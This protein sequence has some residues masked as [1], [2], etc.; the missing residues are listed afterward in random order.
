MREKRKLA[1]IVFTDIVGYT[2][3]MS[4]D[5]P[6]ALRILEKNRELQQLIV[7]KHHGKF[8]KE[9][10]D[11]T[12]LSFR[13]TLDAVNCALEI[14]CAIK[15]DE[16]LKLRIGIHLGDIVFRGGDVFGDGVNVA[17]RVEQHAASGCICVSEPVYE[18]IKNKPGIDAEYVGE[19][20]LKNVENPVKLY[21]LRKE[22][23]AKPSKSL[24]WSKKWLWLRER[25]FASIAIVILGVFAVISIINLIK[26]RE[27]VKN[28]D[29]GLIAVA[30]FENKSGDESLDPIGFMASD[31]ITQGIAGTGLVSVVPSFTL[32][33]IEGIHQNMDGI[34][35]L[36]KETQ[37]QTIITGVFYKQGN[38]IQFHSNVVDAADGEILN[39]VGPVKGPTSDPLKSIEILRQKLMG[40][41]AANFDQYFISFSDRTLQPPLFDA[42][43]EFLAGQELYYQ[44]K[45]HEAIHHFY[46]AAK[47]DTS[48]FL[49][50]IWASGVHFSNGFT[51]DN[52]DEYHRSDSL[53]KIIKKH[54]GKLTPGEQHL[55]DY[56][57]AWE[58]GDLEGA[59][60]AARLTAQ[61][62]LVFKYE[63]GWAALRAN[64]LKASIDVMTALEPDKYLFKGRYWW[65]L[66][67]AHHLSG[68]YKKE[69]KI[70]QQGRN[71]HPELFSALW[72]ELRALSAIGNIDEITRLYEQS[73]N[74]PSEPYWN[75]GYLMLW[76][77][78]ELHVH[79]YKDESKQSINYAIDWYNAHPD[80]DYRYGLAQAYYIAE[81][82]SRSRAIFETLAKENP[83]NINYQGYLGVIAVRTGN[84]KQ[85]E[86]I[87]ML[88][89]DPS[90][91]YL[92]GLN[93]CW[94]ARISALS[95]DKEKA[96]H[97]IR[98]AIAQGFDYY[99]LH[100]IIDFESMYD[101]PP[102]MDL[103]KSKK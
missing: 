5:E 1:A 6:E 11:G 13:S 36:A 61:Y 92:F 74:F 15:D 97:L 9:M 75:P 81:Q 26:N 72:N 30:V 64:H 67:K 40:S 78:T 79:G 56:L 14:Q 88:L 2:R 38:E 96:I 28:L 94:Q 83:G 31:W 20:Y 68:N 82:W 84:I 60:Q 4:R 49:P 45:F 43:Q 52:I 101:Y 87:S 95:D 58:K 62:N 34:L 18:T 8:L 32:E 89:A 42:Y 41:L 46:I 63:L 12:L 53:N 77:A 39:A 102:F 86:T 57:I 17:S 22:N 73:L 27:T 91:P 55:L 93:T 71:K 24:F 35:S 66:T 21:A 65:V 51:S 50:L 98:E 85:A 48:Y 19:K 69:L 90:R 47:L 3:L 25:K 33:T 76:T 54:Q 103:I 44:Y 10:G 29:R 70:A 59:F 16:K 7:R 37:A 23:L 100:E 80:N 99:S